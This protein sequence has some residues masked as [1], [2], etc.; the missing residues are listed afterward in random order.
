MIRL[1][2]YFVCEVGLSIMASLK[3]KR[4]ELRGE[5]SSHSV[6]DTSILYGVLQ[7]S[8][9]DKTAYILHVPA[10]ARELVS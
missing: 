5:R 4:L 10:S 9:R 3:K 1:F 6:E 8:Y 2:S 7:R